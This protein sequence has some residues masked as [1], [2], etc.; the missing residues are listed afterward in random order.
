MAPALPE[1][2]GKDYYV[3]QQHRAPAHMENIVQVLCQENLID[4]LDKTLW[5]PSSP[6]LSPLEFYVWS[7]ML[8]KQSEHQVST[9]D[10]FKKLISKIW[11]KMPMDQ[12]RAAYEFFEKRL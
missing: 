3:F 5:P 4:F 12:V 1:L 8:A 10:H 9:M 7:Y 6:D 2:H 11:D